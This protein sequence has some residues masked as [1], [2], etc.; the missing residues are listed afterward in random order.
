MSFIISILVAVYF[1]NKGYHAFKMNRRN[2]IVINWKYLTL[3]LI[4]CF[5]ANMVVFKLVSFLL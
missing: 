4:T 2:K 5:V 1:Y 3:F